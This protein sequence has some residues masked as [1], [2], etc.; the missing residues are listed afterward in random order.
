[1]RMI[2]FIEIASSN[3]NNLCQEVEILKSVKIIIDIYNIIKVLVPVL[4]IL[5]SIISFAKSILNNDDN[6]KDV[7]SV[8]IQ[9]FII[10]AFIFFV[11]SLV[12]TVF[13]YVE[14]NS[15]FI[16]ISECITNSDNIAYYESLRQNKD[17]QEAGKK[18]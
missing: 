2:G 16:N 6:I 5:V 7:I 10:G 12:F 15:K 9:R 18:D 4:I 13:S 17:K 1:M 11:P 8:F 3:S 14:T